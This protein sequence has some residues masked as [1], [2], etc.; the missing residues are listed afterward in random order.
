M[1]VVYGGT[2]AFNA[3]VFGDSH[4]ANTAYFQNQVSSLGNTLTGIGQQFFADAAQVYERFNGSEV[5]RLAKA[6]RRAVTGLFVPN[7]IIQI[8]TI[9]GLQQARPIMQRWVMANPVVRELWQNQGC[10]GYSDTY[11]DNAP[12]KIGEDHYDYR[13]VM[14]GVVVEK[15]NGESWGY[16]LYVEDELPDDKP[17]NSMD[18]IEILNTW[19]IAAM[20]IHAKGEDP[21]SPFNTS[22]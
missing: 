14:D 22:L 9:G 20:F 17:L 1:Q 12:G 21:T 7:E 16:K 2:D 13:K 19:D 11:I 3:L 18:K 15:D 10:D 4:P 6:A 5:M 8:N